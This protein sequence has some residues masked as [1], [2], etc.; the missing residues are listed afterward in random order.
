MGPSHKISFRELIELS[1]DRYRSHHPLGSDNP[2]TRKLNE[3][4]AI[5]AA[6][7]DIERYEE[8]LL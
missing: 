2:M 1:A 5:N 4:L 6:S 8:N 3:I 7:T